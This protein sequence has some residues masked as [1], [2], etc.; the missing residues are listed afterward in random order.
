MRRIDRSLGRRSSDEPR[1]ALTDRRALHRIELE[2]EAPLAA[3]GERT[4]VEVPL[5]FGGGPQVGEIVTKRECRRRQDD[6]SAA[7]PATTSGRRLRRARR[8]TS[9]QSA[10]ASCGAAARMRASICSSVYVIVSLLPEPR[11]QTSCVPAPAPTSPRPFPR[12]R[13]RTPRSPSMRGR[14]SSGGRRSA[15]V[16]ARARGVPPST[17]V[18]RRLRQISLGR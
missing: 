13:R 7:P 4:D 14:R 9:F 1:I 8:R 16:A 6:C 10:P 11:A 12:S 3:V 17:P 18:E 5:G 2:R 15:G